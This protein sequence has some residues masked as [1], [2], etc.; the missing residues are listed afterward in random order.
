MLLI[1][2]FY[3]VIERHL[4]IAAADLDIVGDSGG[5]RARKRKGMKTPR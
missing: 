4:K 2:S 1:L 3:S 5:K